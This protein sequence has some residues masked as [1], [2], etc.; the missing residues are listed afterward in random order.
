MW[1]LPGQGIEPMSPALA[2]GFFTTDPSGKPLTSLFTKSVSLFTSLVKVA[3]SWLTLCNHTNCS[4]PGSSV[5]G[6]LQERILEWIAM[7]S[8]RGSSWL[9]NQTR[10]SYVFCIGRWVLYYQHHLASPCVVIA[11]YSSY[12][13]FCVGTCSHALSPFSRHNTT[14]KRC[15]FMITTTFHLFLS[16]CILLFT[17]PHA[18]NKLTSII[19]RFNTL[20]K[21]QCW[22]GEWL[23]I[24]RPQFH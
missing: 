14:S 21:V 11:E 18:H 23:I 5:H 24:F 15:L 10:V 6:I 4:P 20:E 1:D 16:A 17:L 8:S 2:G 12:S 19:H 7:P 13:W 9:S 22:M 3:Q